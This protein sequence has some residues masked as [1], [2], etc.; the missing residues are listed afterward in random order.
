MILIIDFGSQTTHLIGRR[1]KEIGVP[2]EIVTAGEALN[3]AI[4]LNPKGIILSG[5]PASTYGK[6]SLLVDKKIFQ[7]GIPVLGICYGLEVMGQMLGGKVA[8][9][10]KKEYGPAYVRLN[11]TSAGG[12]PPFFQ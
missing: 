8:P 11:R 9:G 3:A 2:V 4:K 5:G 6:N 12:T 7:L 10:K 1:I